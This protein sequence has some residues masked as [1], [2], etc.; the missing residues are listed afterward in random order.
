MF[1]YEVVKD[2]IFLP[3]EKPK[4]KKAGMPSLK[5]QEQEITCG[6]YKTKAKL[7]SMRHKCMVIMSE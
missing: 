2:F 5:N 6:I 4:R 7:N 1:C 3:Q